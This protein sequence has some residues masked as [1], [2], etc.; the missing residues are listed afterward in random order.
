MSTAAIS[1]VIICYNAV[2]TIEKT[3][4]S[5]SL[6]SDDIIIVDS[7]ST[8]GTQALARTF[9][10]KLLEMEWGGFGLTKN[11]GNQLAK[12]DWI[13]SLDADEELSGE[14][15]GSIKNLDFTNTQKVYKIKRLNYL[16]HRPIKHG[17]WKDDWTMRIF[18]RN[19]VQWDASPVH[20]NLILP[21]K[22]QVCPLNGLLYHY[23]AS[24]IEIYNKK[25]DRYASLMAEKYFGERVSGHSYKVLISPFFSFFKSYFLRLGILDKRAGWQIAIAHAAYTYKKYKRLQELSRKKG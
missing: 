20:E 5:A 12:N 10:A 2:E 9:P 23:T 19:L 7:G 1:V 21:S 8:D 16:N 14:L 6:V 17:I 25:L 22:T 11:K 18:N 3:L 13:L 4:Q 15:I 24:S